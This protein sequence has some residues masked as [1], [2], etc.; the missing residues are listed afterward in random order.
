M[1]PSIELRAAS[2][3]YHVQAV[4]L[5]LT[6]GQMLVGRVARQR[7]SWTVK[8]A[9]DNVSLSIKTGER[10]GIIGRNGAGKSTLLKMIAGLAEP[11][12]GQ[13]AVEGRITAIMTLGLGLRE[14]LTGRENIYV[15]GEVQG[16][17]RAEV[18]CVIEDIIEFADIGEFIDYP[19]RTYSSGMKARLSFATL[20]HIIPEILVIDEALSV[21]DAAFAVK[22]TAKMKELCD[23]GKI[24]IIVSHGMESVVDMCNRC[25]WMEDGRIVMDGDPSSVTWAYVEAVRRRDEEVLL[26]RFRALV[27]A[28]SYRLG[29]Q[30]IHL[31][32]RHED[33]ADGQVIL[34]AGKDVSIDVVLQVDTPLKSPDLRLRIIR[35]DGLVVTSNRMSEEC[36]KVTKSFQGVIGYSIAMR[37]LVLAPGVYRMVVELM[38]KDQVV[39]ER[40]TIVEVVALRVPT[41]GRTAL[42]Y[43]CSVTTQPTV[44]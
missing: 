7:P 8:V 14:D 23:K 9:V 31:T 43:P 35:L 29:C 22:A 20:I 10:V 5:A 1:N 41:G 38:D 17:S 21:G 28:K 37:P 27:G 12:S 3:V 15:D 32:A 18:D 24:I 39:A 16:R 33:D 30:V 13:V 4:E 40:S 25:L 2:K 44:A 36:G 26:D 6:L 34:N 42:L 19:V 11:T